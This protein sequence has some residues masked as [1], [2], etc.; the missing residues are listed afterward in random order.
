MTTRRNTFE[1]HSEEI[2]EALA[3]GASRRDAAREAGISPRTIDRW[4]AAGRKDR[5]SKYGAFVGVVEEAR[6]ALAG[7]VS[8]REMSRDEVMRCL[9]RA[10]RAGSVP[11]M[12]LWLEIDRNREGS[13]ERPKRDLLSSLDE[14]AARRAQSVAATGSR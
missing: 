7:V 11:A 6:A 5:T 4:F 14:L 1:A 3:A 13:G 12:K 10:I 8:S 9:E 2:A